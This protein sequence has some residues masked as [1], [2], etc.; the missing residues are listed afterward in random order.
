MNALAWMMVQTSR[1][2]RMGLRERGQKR[3]RAREER[4][5]RRRARKLVLERWEQQRKV[6]LL[7]K[8]RQVRRPLEK[9]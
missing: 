3:R 1:W 2:L 7:E 4:M 6:L 8:G 5:K 9:E